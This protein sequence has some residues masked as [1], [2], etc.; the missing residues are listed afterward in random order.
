M[1]PASQSYP[2][3]ATAKQQTGTIELSRNMATFIPN[4]SKKTYLMR[5]LLTKDV[6]FVWTGNMEQEFKSI[7]EAIANCNATQLTHFDP[8]KQMVI[9]T[10]T[11]LKGLGAV[12]IQEGKPVKF[13]S[14]SLTKM[15]SDYS[16]IERELLAVLFSCEKLHIYL[17]GR[18]VN[19]HTDHQPLETICKKPIS[20]APARMQRMLL[21]LRMYSLQVKYVGAKSFLVADTPSRLVKPGTNP[22]VPDLN[23]TIAQVL[24]IRPTHVDSLQEETKADPTLSPLCDFIN[25]GWSDSVHN[26]REALHP[27]WCFLDELTILDGLVMEGNHVVVPSPLRTETLT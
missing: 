4:L 20:L 26:M 5:G 19:M 18:L 15:E 12:L 2:K 17:Y 16:N 25:N 9:E 11:S 7:K 14:K 21:R 10:D 8:N 23:F 22:A 24:K 1:P 13:L 3:T 27:Y 6:N